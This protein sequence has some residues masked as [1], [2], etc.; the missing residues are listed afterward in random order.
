MGPW[1]RQGLTLGWAGK[2][3]TAIGA[4]TS[5]LGKARMLLLTVPEFSD[6]EVESH[7]TISA[8]KDAEETENTNKKIQRTDLSGG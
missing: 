4:K 8:S 2:P 5:K 1:E 7:C 3:S 6:K